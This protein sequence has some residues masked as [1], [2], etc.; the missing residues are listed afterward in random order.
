[1][2][3]QTKELPL[4]PLTLT[5]KQKIKEKKIG[6]KKRRKKYKTQKKQT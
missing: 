1:V 5:S 4:N 3:S 2:L 6:K